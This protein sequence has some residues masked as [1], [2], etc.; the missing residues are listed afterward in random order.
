VLHVAKFRHTMLSFHLFAALAASTEGGEMT[1]HRAARVPGRAP[2]S[3]YTASVRAVGSGD[4]GW[5]Q[6]YV[7][8][9]IAKTAPLEG[10][11][12]TTNQSGCGY[13]SHL[14]GWTS[15]WISIEADSTGAGLE[16]RVQ[17]ISSDVRLLLQ[18]MR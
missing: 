9:T 8:E 16:V 2:S 3:Y 13:F 6:A 12:G 18:M 15:S 1:R 5:V 4:G 10:V 11:A 17:R 7:F 14:N